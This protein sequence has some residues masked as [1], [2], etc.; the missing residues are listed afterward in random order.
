M[1]HEADWL[2]AH[3][4]DVS[5][6]PR[7]GVVF[8]DLT[9]LMADAHAFSFCVDAIADFYADRPIDKVVGIEARGFIFAAPVAYRLGAGLVPVRKAARLPWKVESQEYALEYGSGTLEIHTDAVA[10][11]ES[12]LVIDDVLATGG[13]AR[14]TL[15][16][17]DRLG[18]V[19]AGMAFVL[20]LTYL[21]GRAHLDHWTNR[22]DGSGR[23][24]YEPMSLLEFGSV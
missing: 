11:G 8:K 2:R 5:G 12:V 22:G 10:E 23:T 13:T 21:G 24:P 4:R 20:E 19:V 16:M 14:A 6:F 7:P 18:A 1:K 15:E 17:L 3:V 9:P